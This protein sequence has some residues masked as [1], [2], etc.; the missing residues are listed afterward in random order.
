MSRNEEVSAQLRAE[1]IAGSPSASGGDLSA[2]L[3]QLEALT[4]RFDEFSRKTNE[5]LDTQLVCIETCR[6]P[7]HNMYHCVGDLQRELQALT[8]TVSAMQD[9]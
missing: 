2:V 3:A 5:A 6:N 8:D 9:Q 4:H 7:C 1:R